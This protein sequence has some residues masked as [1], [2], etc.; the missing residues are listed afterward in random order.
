MLLTITYHR[1]YTQPSILI[2]TKKRCPPPKD[3]MKILKSFHTRPNK[4]AFNIFDCKNT[5]CGD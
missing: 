4:V 3:R 2:K 5:T 1:R